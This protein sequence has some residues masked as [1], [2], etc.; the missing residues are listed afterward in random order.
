MTLKSGKVIVDELAVANAHPSGAQPFARD[1][2]IQKFKIL[3]DGI[4]VAA[5][6]DRFLELVQNLPDLS[7]ADV[8]QINVQVPEDKID[9]GADNQGIF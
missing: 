8:A 7:A 1:D 2:Y 9:A 4:I 5:E 3:T 6:R